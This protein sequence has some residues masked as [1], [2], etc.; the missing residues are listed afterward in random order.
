MYKRIYIRAL[1]A[2]MLAMSATTTMAVDVAALSAALSGGDRADADKARDAGRKPAQVVAFLGISEGMTVMD[3]I[4]A[5]GYYTEVL[6]HAVGE[7]GRVYAQNPAMVLR[8]RDG[9]NDKAMAARLANDRL[10]NVVRWDH[11]MTDIGL[12]AGSLD[13][14]IT[15]L[16]FHDIY[17]NDPAVAADFLTAVMQLLK[18]GG[19]LGII[20]HHGN[21][22]ADNAALHRMEKSKALEAITAAGFEVVGDSDLLSN[23]ADDRT[24]M[25]FAADLRGK[26]DRFLVK[27]RKPG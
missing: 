25:V 15:A 3:L 27:L 20:D 11:E 9:A 6:A 22:G 12:D 10:P 17:N 23:A 14:A 1:F 2:L 8:F 7:S 18:P 21:A 24:Q 26:T 4:A 13:A 16:N 19:V 5:G